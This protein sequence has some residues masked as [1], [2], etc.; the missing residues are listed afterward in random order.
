LIIKPKNTT[1]FLIKAIFYF[2]IAVMFLFL[3]FFNG[4]I[5]DLVE[6]GGCL[7]VVFILLKGLESFFDFKECKGENVSLKIE[8][9]ILYVNDKKVPLKNKYLF[10]ESKKCDKFFKVFLYEE[11]DTKTNLLL[12]TIINEEEYIN[13]LK[14]IKP[15]KKLPIYL[16]ET[17]GIFLCKNGFSL[18]GRE[19]FYN[20]ISSI[21]W[22][23]QNSYCRFTYC[24]KKIYVYITLKNN[25]LIKADFYKND[26]VYAKL[27]YINMAIKKKNKIIGNKKIVKIFNNLIEKIKKEDCENIV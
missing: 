4:K 12:K 6:L 22:E 27:I 14:L 11:K 5:D 17:K 24:A 7:V 26:L 10:L 1:K 3:I 9:D 13:L 18:N 8:N 15:Y 2:I 16:S 25:V 20:E 23:T 19:F 21:E